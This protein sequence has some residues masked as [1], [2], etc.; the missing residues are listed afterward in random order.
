M[1]TTMEINAPLAIK[2]Q[3]DFSSA[4]LDTKETPTVA[5]KKV[6]PEAMIDCELY[7]QAICAASFLVCPVDSSS[8]NRVVMRM[9]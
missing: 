7:S 5:P 4:I 2:R 1:I 8:S 6:N 3:I 9:A